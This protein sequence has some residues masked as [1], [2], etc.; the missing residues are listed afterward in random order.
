M[1]G[2]EVKLVLLGTHDSSNSNVVTFL[3]GAVSYF[4]LYPYTFSVLRYLVLPQVQD[5]AE[6]TYFSVCGSEKLNE[7]V[8]L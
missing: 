7:F 1:W 2:Q 4:L 3:V 8:H 6:N 5:N